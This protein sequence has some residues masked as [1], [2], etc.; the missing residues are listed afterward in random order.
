MIGFLRDV[1]AQA[2][3]AGVILVILALG[4]V[5]YFVL[6]AK[7]FVPAAPKAKRSDFKG[8]ETRLD[9]LTSEV[10]GVKRRLTEVERDLEDRPTKADLHQLDL[11]LV[12]QDERMKAI[13]NVTKATNAG[14][15]R[16]EEFMI[17]AS[18]K[19]GRK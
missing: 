14:V 17:E 15:Q 8:I 18:V 19:A 3:V 4:G 12:R 9:T 7:G 11:V 5:A 2:G 13:E 6:R 10:G 16:L 1:L